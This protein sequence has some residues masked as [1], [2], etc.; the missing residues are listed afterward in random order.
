MMSMDISKTRNLA[1]AP[2]VHIRTH[3][4]EETEELGGRLASARPPDTDALAVIHLTGDLGAGKTTFARGFLRA[5]GVEE[6]VRSPTYTLL[7]LH[8]LMKQTILHVDLYR[9]RDEAELESLGIR[10]WAGPGCLWLIEW[11]ERAGT[12]LPPPDLILTF[13]VGVPAHQIELRAQTPHGKQWLESLARA[14]RSGA[15][16]GRKR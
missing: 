11:P 3:S 14:G 6:P 15:P 16:P 9:L 13:T 7:E 4:A 10:D 5:L 2:L 12:R 1:G 8:E